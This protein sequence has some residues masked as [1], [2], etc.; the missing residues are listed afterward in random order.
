[1]AIIAPIRAERVTPPMLDCR[2]RPSDATDVQAKRL[3]ILLKGERIDLHLERLKHR[4][5]T[6]F[7]QR[8]AVIACDLDSA[9]LP[10]TAPQVLQTYLCIVLEFSRPQQ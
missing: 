1:M 9:R 10:A 4:E 8:F 5:R 2:F 3:P 6:G 7:D